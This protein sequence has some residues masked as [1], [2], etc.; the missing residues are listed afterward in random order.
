MEYIKQKIA[1][2]YLGVTARHKSNY[3]QARKLIR[4]LLKHTETPVDSAT[5]EKLILLCSQESEYRETV[6]C[7]IVKL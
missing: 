7:L 6:R 2:L 3:P 1:N 5:M 4:S